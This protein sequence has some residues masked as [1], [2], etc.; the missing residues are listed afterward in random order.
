MRIIAISDTHSQLEKVKIPDGDILIH[1][2]DLTYNGTIKETS[3]ELYKLSRYE[4]KFKEI[5]YVEGNHDWLGAR[6][7]ILMAQMC[8]DN[9]V[10][11]LRDSGITIEGLSI[12]GSPWQPEF[13]NWSFN[14]PRGPKLKEKWDLIPDNINVLIT[15]GPPKGILDLVPN[16][17]GFH[18]GCDDLYDRVMQLKNLK[19]HVFGHLHMNYGSLKIGNTIFANA[20]TC[21]ESYLPENKPLIF[22]I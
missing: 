15:H 19:L 18:A 10:T 3:Q 8:R 6:D 5:I 9:G 22:D 21:T 14:L 1:S 11:L 7:P 2:G 17:K 13:C 20:A 16:P 4:D 12:Y